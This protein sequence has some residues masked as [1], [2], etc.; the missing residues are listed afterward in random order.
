[1]LIDYFAYL[2]APEKIESLDD[3]APVIE[4]YHHTVRAGKYDEAIELYR[5]RLATQLFFKF[6]AYQTIIK[7]LREFF[8]DGE[9]KPPRLKRA[10]AHGYMLN[11][12]ANS[13]SLSGQPRKAVRTFQVAA[14][15][16]DKSKNKR[17]LAVSLGN[18]AEQQSALGEL[19][20]AETNLMR[21]IEHLQ[22]IEAELDEPI[23]RLLLGRMLAYQGEFLRSKKDLD[24]VQAAID[25]IIKRGGRTNLNST[26]RACKSVLFLFIF[27]VDEAFKSAEEAR[28]LA[29][30]EKGERDIIRAEYLLG[31]AYL[32]KGNF[33][34]AEK[35][36]TEALTRDRKI[37]LVELEPDILL[38]FAKLRFKQNYKP[39][40]LKHIEEALQIADRCEYRLKQADIHN[41]LAEFYL[42]AGD[43]EKAKEH[44]EKAKE[45]A[46]CGYKPAMDKAEKLLDEIEQK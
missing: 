31:A 10:N 32:M 23:A 3:L 6:S 39:E 35:H 37:N 4:L 44:A 18:L 29:D 8:P 21:S 34:E 26:V 45:R 41:F 38:E 30:V 27:N 16:V 12:L 22:E 42:D 25:D 20:A 9:D 13:Y 15:L 1:M 2:P 33:T 36:L 5:E 17:D 19:D 11:E 28:E 14:Y 46:E 24:A 43:V 7:L 40:V